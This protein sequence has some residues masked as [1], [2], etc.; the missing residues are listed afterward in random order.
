MNVLFSYLICVSLSALS[1]SVKQTCVIPKDKV[2]S[3]KNKMDGRQKN[4]QKKEANEGWAVFCDFHEITHAV[5]KDATV[6]IYRQDNKR[7]VRCTDQSKSTL[8]PMR[9]DSILVTDILIC[10]A[11][12]VTRH[13]YVD[14]QMA[15]YN[16]RLHCFT[17]SVRDACY[18]S[19]HIGI[20]HDHQ[21]LF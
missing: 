11:P 19:S 16:A 12:A 18:I 10:L 5:I 7:M 20:D 4:E 21:F 2:K 13:V 9:S 6:T 17:V 15:V 14:K 8:F 3:K 1:V